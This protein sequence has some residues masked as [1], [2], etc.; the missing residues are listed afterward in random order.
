MGDLQVNP[1][2]KAAQR[3]IREGDLITTINGES[4]KTLTSNEAHDLLKGSGSTL[5]LGLNE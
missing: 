2:S 1:G 3:G 5:K 4:T